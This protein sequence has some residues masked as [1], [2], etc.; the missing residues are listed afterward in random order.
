MDPAEWDRLMQKKKQE[1]AKAAGGKPKRVY[2]SVS[3]VSNTAAPEWL[4]D[5][6]PM[7]WGND[8][9]QIKRN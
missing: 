9:I 5:D 3:V 6:E 4:D 1:E 2:A 8:K 7:A